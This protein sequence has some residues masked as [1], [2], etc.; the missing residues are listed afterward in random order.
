M[1]SDFRYEQFCPLARATEI[2]GS[3]W[4]L[5]I[6]RE[7]FTGPRRFADLRTGLPGISSSV[8]SERLAWLEGLGM[9]ARRELEAPASG[10]V[11]VLG[12]NGEAF[13]PACL[14]LTR[15]GARFLLPLHPGDHLEARWVPLGLEA[16]AKRTPSPALRFELHIADEPRP[17]VTHVHG[18]PEGTVVRPD[19]ISSDVRLEAGPLDILTFAGGM[20]P[21][22]EAVAQG[23]ARAEGDLAVL[24]ELPR[25][26]TMDLGTPQAPTP[27][28]P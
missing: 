18:G 27:S 17:L 12:P 20:V 3:R 22:S 4:T 6:L 13:R 25:L 11:Y 5:L 10:S 16:F 8:L 24:D 14:E 23:R 19:A 7:L 1:P 26:F 2:L 28:N 15:W 21:P 9:V